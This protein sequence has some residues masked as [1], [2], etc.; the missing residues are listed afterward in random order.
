V[1]TEEQARF[2]EAPAGN[3]N[4][5][6]CPGSGKTFSG[7]RRF[8]L[9]ARSTRGVAYLSFTRVAAGEAR[10]AAISSHE[11]RSL[12][13]PNYMGTIDAFVRQHIFDP[14]IKSL[15]PS[16]GSDADVISGRSYVPE[17]IDQEEH[18][19]FDG[20]RRPHKPWTIKLKAD[21]E[22]FHFVLNNN[23]PLPEGISAVQ[24]LQAKTSYLEA[25]LLTHNDVL[26]WSLRIL[27]SNDLRAREILARC[28]PEIIVDEAQ[29]TSRLQ[30]R[31]LYHIE[32]GGSVT[33]Y[34]GDPLQSIYKFN[35]AD[36][37]ILEHAGDR[38]IYNLSVN[39]RSS[40]QIVSLVNATYGT[41]MTSTFSTVTR[42]LGLA[43]VIGSAHECS[44][45]FRELLSAAAIPLVNAAIVVRSNALRN[46]L[47]GVLDPER[48]FSLA[49]K[50]LI[51][52]IAA[53]Q[54][55]DA[56]DTARLALD[57]LRSVLRISIS[58][59]NERREW[60]R[61]AWVFLR[62]E[63]PSFG[64]DTV[65]IWLRKLREQVIEC[66]AK[67]DVEAVHNLGV[68][69][70]RRGINV[71]LARDML[72]MERPAIRV[73]TVHGVKGESIDAVLLYGTERQ[74][75]AWLD[76]RR[77]EDGL[78]GYVGLTRAQRLLVLGCPDHR[79]GAEW[80]ARL[81][82]WQVCGVP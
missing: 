74:H 30:Q 41:N 49:L 66:A 10:A 54:D 32:Q 80:S 12:L 24:V 40:S 72:N 20:R 60:Q 2:V 67:Y 9:R 53:L 56:G 81:Q 51:S 77:T 57:F 64:D 58:D 73:K 3:L 63:L 25:G 17:D 75:R 27:S 5:V 37:M 50:R 29:D 23:A 44:A 14:F 48:A 38:I 43:V 36:A 69:L 18:W 1:L 78:L 19:L 45:A 11:S 52:A 62:R 13:P 33:T 6:A 65:E 31:I 28:F 4:L 35:D 76:G 26:M 39:K 21:G 22:A 47:G 71:E 46:E 82:E 70:Q 59:E 42:R 55:G 61:R 34:I 7:V 15:I 68:R 16:A 8:L 79:T